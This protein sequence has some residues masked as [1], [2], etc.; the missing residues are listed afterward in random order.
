MTTDRRDFIG[1]SFK[2]VAGAWIATQAASSIALADTHS[3]NHSIQHSK[4][5]TKTSSSSS[6][7]IQ[8]QKVNKYLTQVFN[9]ATDCTKKGEICHQHCQ[10][11]LAEG[12]THF[13]HCNTAVQQMMV[14]SDAA[15]KLAGMKAVKIQDILDT[16]VHAAQDCVEACK[17]HESHWSKGM[18]LECKEC[19]SS[20][21]QFI[22]A[23]NDLKKQL[24]V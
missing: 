17:E 23:C 12:D 7:Q 1:S 18:H 10:E 9:T 24:S 13:S 21:E 4:D 14:F 15:A 11:R 3:A 22:S 8:N 6:L 2:T 19:A 20:C 16:A 5:K